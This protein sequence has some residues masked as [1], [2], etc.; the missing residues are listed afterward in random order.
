MCSWLAINAMKATTTDTAAFVDDDDDE[1][2]EASSSTTCFNADPVNLIVP[3][4]QATK[5][6]G[7]VVAVEPSVPSAE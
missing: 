3:P 4:A 7:Q 2:G 6:G 5:N 1:G